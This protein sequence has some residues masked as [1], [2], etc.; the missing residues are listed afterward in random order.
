MG[1]MRRTQVA[2]E[3]SDLHARASWNP[4]WNIVSI[5]VDRCA[6]AHGFGDHQLCRPKQPLDC[7]NPGSTGTWAFFFADWQFVV[8]VF[9]ELFAIA[10]LWTGRLVE[11]PPSRGM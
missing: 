11:R 2:H 1:N 6:L 3:R 10:A 9:L 5:P 8:R 7:R 4:S